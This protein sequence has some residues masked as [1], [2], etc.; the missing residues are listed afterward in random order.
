MDKL[1]TILDANMSEQF[2]KV[3][4]ENDDEFVGKVTSVKIGPGKGDIFCVESADDDKN[5][6]IESVKEVE[7]VER[8]PKAKYRYR[9][10]YCPLCKRKFMWEMDSEWVEFYYVLNSTGEKARQATCTTCGTKLAV[11]DGALE[12]VNPAERED[13]VHIREYGL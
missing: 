2:L 6:K 5:F 8:L 13:L 11:F 4:D 7:I 9:E 1:A 10:V 12:G 3:I